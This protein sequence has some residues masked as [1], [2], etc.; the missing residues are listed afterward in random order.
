MRLESHHLRDRAAI[1]EPPAAARALPVHRFFF[2]AVFISG[3][4]MPEE[5]L[6]SIVRPCSGQAK[7]CG[8]IHVANRIASPPQFLEL[9]T[10]PNFQTALRM[11]ARAFI[12]VFLTRIADTQKQS[13]RTWCLPVES[14]R[15]LGAATRQS[16]PRLRGNRMKT[17]KNEDARAA[18][19]IVAV[20]H[21]K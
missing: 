14:T 12:A 21:P 13:E 3:M 19:K 4:R 20:V 8:T 2:N 6:R 18:Q 15:M 10:L 7:G 1:G 16:L 9:K 17:S 11:R 5:L